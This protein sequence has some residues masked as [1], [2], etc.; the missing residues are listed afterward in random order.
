MNAFC[1][2]SPSPAAPCIIQGSLPDG[3]AGIACSPED[4]RPGDLGPEAGASLREHGE[5]AEQLF[6]VG[7]I[8]ATG[9]TTDQRGFPLDSPTPDIGAFQY[10]GPP[11]TVTIS[12]PTTGTVQVEGTFTLTAT[13]PTP[14]DQDD[15]FSYTIDWNGDGS[16]IQTIQGPASLEVAHAYGAAGPYTPI[17]TALDQDHR[18]S[19]LATVASP[20]VVS[21]L[22][23]NVVSVVLTNPTVIIDV[24]NLSEAEIALQTINGAPPTAWST[25]LDNPTVVHLNVTSPVVFDTE[26]DPT[27]ADAQVDVS[28]PDSG[29]LGITQYVSVTNPYASGGS[30]TLT[31]VAF[32]SAIVATAIIGGAATGDV[33]GN[34]ATDWEDFLTEW[35]DVDPETLETTTS[36]GLQP[37]ATGASGIADNV[38]A[39][40]AGTG[41]LSGTQTLQTLAGYSNYAVG[42]SPAVTVVQ[43]TVTWSNSLMGTATDALTIVVRGGTLIPMDDFVSGN[44]AGSQALIEVDGGTLILGAPDDTHSNILATDGSA[45]FVHVAGML[46]VEPGNAFNR[47]TFDPSTSTLTSQAAGLTVTQLVSSAPAALPGQAVTLTATVTT[48]GAPASDGTVEFFDH[49][50]G[51]FL[52]TAPV[53]LAASSRAVAMG[54]VDGSEGPASSLLENSEE[55]TELA[56][57]LIGGQRQRIEDLATG[58]SKV[59]T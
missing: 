7:G 5:P 37:N 6:P 59:P 22:D 23:P 51:T 18:S 40:G 1:R 19:G 3:L 42:V 2:S 29:L 55:L 31:Q 33:A 24:A 30:Q 15:T 9:V 38:V 17:V 49:T 56:V 21:P 10:Q 8:E 47:V 36:V 52:G 27:S 35:V 14:A 57:S 16:D 50:N 54:P 46:I 26:I 25:N 13:D 44:F 20:I 11:P 53:L 34:A 41:A 4:S 45:P 28:G 12:G 48:A 32:I 39:V 43:G 58:N